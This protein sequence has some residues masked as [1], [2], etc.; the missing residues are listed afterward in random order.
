MTLFTIEQAEALLPQLRDELT[1]MQ[2]CKR[3]VDE[4]RPGLARAA[5]SATGNGHVKNED[6]LAAKRRQAEA[7]VDEIN[8]RLARIN[9]LGVELKDIDQGLLDFPSEREGRTVYLCW[10]LGEERI[11]WWHELDTGFAGRQAL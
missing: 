6:E 7:L 4:L 3:A 5:E 11:E 9:E 2:R 8:T 10:Q 1:E